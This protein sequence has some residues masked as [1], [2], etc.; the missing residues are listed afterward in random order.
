MESCPLAFSLQRR[1]S[2]VCLYVPGL[3]HHNVLRFDPCCWKWQD[4]I[5][6]SVFLFRKPLLSF[7][8]RGDSENQKE[9]LQEVLCNFLLAGSLNKCTQEPGLPQAVSKSPCLQWVS[10]ESGIC[11]FLSR[12]ET[13]A[14]L[15]PRYSWN[16]GIPSEVWTAVSSHSLLILCYVE[17]SIMYM[18]TTSPSFFHPLIDSWVISYLGYCR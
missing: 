10:H 4:F 14:G 2:S 7:T 18:Y 17:Y 1:R 15:E 11:C 9:N 12:L 6:P 5:L 3:S 13:E 16:V 8:H